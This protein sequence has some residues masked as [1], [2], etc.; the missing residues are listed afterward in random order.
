LLFSGTLPSRPKLSTP[1]SVAVGT[2]VV[3][4]SSTMLHRSVT[5]GG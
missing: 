5:G 1:A 2:K 4:P 3:F